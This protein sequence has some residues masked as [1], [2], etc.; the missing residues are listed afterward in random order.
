MTNTHTL[1]RH[2]VKKQIE[3]ASMG[4]F[5]DPSPLL[6]RTVYFFVKDN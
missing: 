5:F 6:T 3:K 2:C 1:H 4:L